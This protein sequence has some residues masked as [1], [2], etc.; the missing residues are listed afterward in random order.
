MRQFL[1]KS[2]SLP[3]MAI[4]AMTTAFA[5]TPAAQFQ[6]TQGQTIAPSVPNATANDVNAVTAQPGQFKGFTNA[7]RGTL[8]APQPGTVV[9]RLNGKVEVDLNAFSTSANNSANSTAAGGGFSGFKVNPIAFGTLMRLYPGVDGMSTNGLRYGAAAEFRE[10]FGAPTGLS[11]IAPT[12][13]GG[14]QPLGLSGGTPAAGT[15]VAAASSASSYSSSETI[16]VRRMFAYLAADNVGILRLGQADGL[17]GLF[18]PCIFSAQCWDA[19]VGELNAGGI[20]IAAPSNAVLIPFPWVSQSGAEY[21]NTKAVYLSPQIYGVDFGVQY[22]PGMDNGFG[23]STGSTATSPTLCAQPGP[24]CVGTTTGTDGTRWFN[25][26][27]VG[28]RW[29][30][31]FGPVQTGLM[32][33][34]ETAGKESVF[35]PKILSGGPGKVL[36]NSYDN[37]S[38]EEIAGYAALDTGVGKFT[39]SLDWIG[40][41]LNG[42]VAMRPTGGAPENATLTGLMWNQGPLTLGSQVGLIFSQGAQQLTGVSQRREFEMAFGGTY[43]LAP[44]IFLV[45]EY[46]Y[47]QRHQA[48]FDFL[49]GTVGPTRD[50]H[51][52]GITISTVVNW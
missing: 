7:F 14:V 47:E 44:G 38:F 3:A 8:P 26:V 2:T 5:E 50:V 36:G 31:S 13:A 41:A 46:Q 20:Q 33:V 4:A 18:D 49:A 32:G 16:F 37:L 1:L 27:A 12:T 30:G 43:S 24:N 40:G 21:A 48:G 11:T 51:G 29:Q 52:Q 42:Q 39:Y 15:S 45:A 6:P 25:Q 17:I 10:N 22:A 23:A 19:G 28:A 35:G 9:I 34:Y